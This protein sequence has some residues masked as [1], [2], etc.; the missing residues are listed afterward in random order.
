M[1]QT[2][3]SR[4]SNPLFPPKYLWQHA[5]DSADDNVKAALDLAK[6]GK[7]D[8]LQAVRKAADEKREQAVWR[9]WRFEPPRQGTVIL[10]EIVIVRDLLEKIVHWIDI[11]H[12]SD[13]QI[14]EER[15]TAWRLLWSPFWFL[16]RRPVEDVEAFGGLIYDLEYA[17]RLI[18]EFEIM[19]LQ[20]PGLL[21]STDN[22]PTNALALLYDGIL[23]L[24]ASH[25]RTA[26]HECTDHPGS[27]EAVSRAREET[28]ARET[29][30]NLS[31]GL[32]TNKPLTPNRKMYARECHSATVQKVTVSDDLRHQI[33]TWI[34]G[35]IEDSSS[36]N[37]H[38]N[39][40]P[41]G[42]LSVDHLSG[43]KSFGS[44]WGSSSP[45]FL[46]MHGQ[47]DGTDGIC[48]IVREMI[49]QTN[50]QLERPAP[51]FYIDCAGKS[52]GHDILKQ[53]VAELAFKA[54]DPSKT[55]DSV[56]AEY[57]VEQTQAEM[58]GTTVPPM[59]VRG[60]LAA[61]LDII[62]PGP[63]TLLLDQIGE[64]A[65]THV[66]SYMTHVIDN[67]VNVVKILIT[68]KNSTPENAAF[69]IVLG[70]RFTEHTNGVL[71]LLR[72]AQPP[73]YATG[74]ESWHTTLE[75]GS[76]LS[77]ASLSEQ[78]DALIAAV[79]GRGLTTLL[80]LVRNTPGILTHLPNSVLTTAVLN[81][82]TRFLTYLLT[83]PQCATDPSALASAFRVAVLT[84]LIRCTALLLSHQPAA[85]DPNS[86]FS[87]AIPSMSTPLLAAASR[88]HARLIYLLVA[89]GADV[90][91]FAA[92]DRLLTP[93]FVAASAGAL[94]AVKALL[95]ARADGNGT[96]AE[97]AAVA[98]ADAGH[99]AVAKFLVD[100]V[101]EMRR[102]GRKKQPTVGGS[103]SGS[104]FRRRIAYSRY[105]SLLREASPGWPVW[106]RGRRHYGSIVR[107]SV[108]PSLA[109]EDDAVQRLVRMADGSDLAGVEKAMK[110]KVQRNNRE[111]SGNML[112]ALAAAGQLDVVRTIM[113]QRELLD[114][115]EHHVGQ[116][117][118]EAAMA[119][120][121]RFVQLFCESG[122][123]LGD[124]CYSSALTGSVRNGHIDVVDFLVRQ[125]RSEEIPQ[126]TMEEIIRG[127][128]QH[129]DSMALRVLRLAE[130]RFSRK[131]LDQVRMESL[132]HA[133][134]YGH[135]EVVAAI[136]DSETEIDT[137]SFLAA[138]RT[139]CTA[140]RVDMVNEL[141]GRDSRGMIQPLH[142]DQGA[143]IA[144]FRGVKHTFQTLLDQQKLESRDETLHNCLVLAAGNGMQDLTEFLFNIIQ[145]G[146][147]RIYAATRG[148]RMAARN[149]HCEMV[150]YLLD[151]GARINDAVPDISAP[152]TWCWEKRNA[153][154]SAEMT[155]LQACIQGFDRF[156]FPYHRGLREWENGDEYA[157]KL[158]LCLLLD[159]GADGNAKGGANHLPIQN[160][161]RYCPIDVVTLILEAGVD[162]PAAAASTSDLLEGLSSRDYE[163]DCGIRFQILLNTG[164]ELQRIPSLVKEALKYFDGDID[165]ENYHSEGIN[166]DG[167][168][169]RTKS[170]TA[171]L[172]E[173]PGAIIRTALQILPEEKATD[174]RYGLVLQM[175]AAIGDDAFVQLLVERGADVNTAGFYYG[176]ALQAASRFSHLSTVKLLLSAGATV[177]ILQGRHHTA[178]RAAVVGGSIDIV[179][180]L[181]E[182]SADISLSFTTSRLSSSEKNMA[183][184]I[185]Q[186][187]VEHGHLEI[188]KLLLR[189]G[190]P[191]HQDEAKGPSTLIIA[192]FESNTAMVSLLL[193]AGAPVNYVATPPSGILYGDE[194]GWCSA[195]HMACMQGNPDTVQLL[196]DA[197]AD[198]EMSA[199]EPKWRSPLTTAASKNRAAVVRQLLGAGAHADRLSY[200]HHNTGRTALCEAAENGA[201]EA[202]KALLAGGA[203]PHNKE[204]RP[205]PLN[206]ACQR[207][208][209][210]VAE[211]LLEAVSFSEVE[212]P[213]LLCA[214]YAAS[215]AW[216]HQDEVFKLLFEYAPAD[217][218]ALV[219][220]AAAGLSSVVWM[221][222]ESGVNV[223]SVNLAGDTALL[224]AAYNL[225]PDVVATLLEHGA[226]I[227]IKNRHR[228]GPIMS[229]LDKCLGRPNTLLRLMF[230]GYNNRGGHFYTL[231]E[232]SPYD[233]EGAADLPVGEEIVN[234]LLQHGAEAG[235]E[236][237]V[238]ENG[239]TLGSALHLAAFLGSEAIVSALLDHGAAIDMRSGHFETPLFAAIQSSQAVV[240]KC[241]LERGA[242]Y[243]YMSEKRGTPLH[244][245]CHQQSKPIVRLLLR[246]GADANTVDTHGATPLT[247]ALST[248]GRNDRQ[249]FDVFLEE[250]RDVRITPED[251]LAASATE[252]E[253][254]AKLKALLN[255]DTAITPSEDV[256][257]AMLANWRASRDQDL[258]RLVL[259]RTRHIGVTER[260]LCTVSDTSAL[261]ILL[262]EGDSAISAITPAVLEAATVLHNI[263]YLLWI[264]PTV[265]PTGPVVINF[266][267][268]YKPSPLLRG[269]E[270][271]KHTQ[272]LLEVIWHRS[273]DLVVTEEMLLHATT[274]DDMAF[275]MGRAPPDLAVSDEV[276]QNAV[277]RSDRAN[278]LRA[279]FSHRPA[280]QMSEAAAV[281][282]LARCFRESELEFW[283]ILLEYQP[284]LDITAAL[285]RETK[286]AAKWVQLVKSWGR[287]FMV[288]EELREVVE[289]K[290]ASTS[291][292]KL[293]A[294]V[295]SIGEL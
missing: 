292:T 106:E 34:T 211:L 225:H 108:A 68:V 235:D 25:I 65:A 159:R 186:L 130:E 64:Q 261:K 222:L 206:R 156:R 231:Q 119:G 272:P 93:L 38:D 95:A 236:S 174:P 270:P 114:I 71:V 139:A 243:Q 173:G 158:T 209:L 35:E 283:D 255:T 256:V 4:F 249:C 10:R 170:I 90:N 177:N 287:T 268:A 169:E 81:N 152:L 214:M 176:T 199:V 277:L 8:V 97:E 266:L 37:A 233:W 116:A 273:P 72:N 269:Y 219:A 23:R 234:L 160:A 188:A 132:P 137:D 183:P 20:R 118:E 79:K 40:P 98:A 43:L 115:S 14:P 19:D 77:S 148:L 275:L 112:A 49:F 67:S 284:Y 33:Q 136:L 238:L 254:V 29:K 244:F 260:M 133:A 226:D 192:C 83:I 212:E 258:I 196:L 207:G 101:A 62:A 96:R 229:A 290:L 247:A 50:A 280:W 111:S 44:W 295:Y 220:A 228:G 47:Q 167:R 16:L 143:R 56:I 138:F 110:A 11:L 263:D 89:H 267:K 294:M 161:I 105:K 153:G 210:K 6:T 163:L 279:I 18:V 140:G 92:S 218:D 293:K 182:S 36:H 27:E 99:E 201:L 278:V 128:C 172:T 257:C 150:R 121:L 190:A 224:E 241:L 48:N 274:A 184:T 259:S 75:P 178:L 200:C 59:S 22:S 175:A 131:E 2:D 164:A 109:A 154:K 129:G 60:C 53:I 197:G 5:T 227:K 145:D 13:A 250:A 103:G 251:L 239:F 202:A 179:H 73:R 45:C 213:A 61:I 198:V 57:H 123:D 31:L 102:S 63:V 185:M 221:L 271:L 104:G 82:D 288:T 55:W 232:Y 237:P 204:W 107:A 147:R 142:L 46:L 39:A 162:V 215:E 122:L 74:A 141:I 240:V 157:M 216:C 80:S 54:E 291:Q 195:L 203:A 282:G 3:I 9:F 171:A 120:Q 21:I 88:N 41:T 151:R 58:E 289:A 32:D 52:S 126:K 281:K 78:S 1:E 86:L 100:Y 193:S 276:F 181:L 117:L 146:E 248:R 94:D 230:N 208:Q 30:L 189:N 113:E 26:V 76:C 253:P 242:A 217:G 205:N 166:P 134:R 245:A 252:S 135:Q 246:H 191:P 15:Q 149:G 155:A 168:F 42:I 24:L 69:R 17:A 124:R 285:L 84:N 12:H 286:L 125:K 165:S 87:D 187:A 265:V 85:P 127:A 7:R 262:E 66:Q 91:Q 264:A 144:A 194:D 70:H 51:V 28:T 223:N 180:L